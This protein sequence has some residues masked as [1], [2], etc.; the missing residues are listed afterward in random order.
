[1]ERRLSDQD[2]REMNVNHFHKNRRSGKDRRTSISSWINPD[3]EKRS[4]KDRRK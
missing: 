1:M 4:G 3:K 2:I